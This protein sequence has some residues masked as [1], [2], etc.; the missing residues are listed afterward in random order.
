M[1]FENKIAKLEEEIKSKDNLILAKKKEISKLHKEAE[2]MQPTE[3]SEGEFNNLYKAFTGN[4]IVIS[5][6][7][8]I[9][10][11]L[12]VEKY[13]SLLRLLS[14]Q[15]WRGSK[16]MTFNNIP[17][18]DDNFRRFLKN[19]LPEGQNGL[20]LNIQADVSL[21]I[22]KY[23]DYLELAI[24]KITKYFWIQNCNISQ[25]EFV[26]IM[27][28]AKH[29]PDV[30]ICYCRIKINSE[31]CF[32]NITDKW[33]I[34]KL[35]L[36][37]WGKFIYSNWR[38]KPSGFEYIIQAIASCQPLRESLKNMTLKDCDLPKEKIQEIVEYHGLEK[39]SLIGI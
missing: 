11:D 9:L 8:T 20:L 37:S 39:L 14:F 17:E 7:A 36:T 10:F 32:D 22:S 2:L 12:K 19:S 31:I 24:H 5:S 13:K 25:E 30:R 21:D 6:T 28:A 16:F 26:V 18:D 15:R 29:I 4:E 33:A 1:R 3:L 23:I 38:G 27:N 35:D 34:E